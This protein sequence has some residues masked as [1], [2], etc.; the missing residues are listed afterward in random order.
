MDKAAKTPVARTNATVFWHI[1]EQK[2]SSLLKADSE[3]ES[4]GN[5]VGFLHKNSHFQLA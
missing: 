4:Y 3:V 1:L 2:Q 5:P